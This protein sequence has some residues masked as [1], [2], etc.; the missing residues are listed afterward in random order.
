MSTARGTLNKLKSR[1]GE[2]ITEVLAAMVVI[3]LGIIMLVSMEMAAQNLVRKSEASFAAN[4]AQKNAIEEGTGAGASDAA[5]KDTKI[6]L[7]RKDTA[8]NLNLIGKVP[9][10]ED[11]GAESSSGEDTYDLGLFVQD[12]DVQTITAPAEDGLTMRY[13][14]KTAQSGS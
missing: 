10:S 3:A 4:M 14:P 11:A 7:T 1:R 8:K 9:D 2:T 13:M 6:Q 5:V 12:I